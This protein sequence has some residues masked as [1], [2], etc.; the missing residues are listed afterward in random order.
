MF[1]VHICYQWTSRN[2]GRHINRHLALHFF[3]LC[4]FF[5]SIR[6]INLQ[7]APRRLWETRVPKWLL[8]SWGSWDIHPM[9]VFVHEK[10]TC[11]LYSVQF[12]M[13][14]KYSHAR[15]SDSHVMFSPSRN[16]SDRSTTNITI[17][18]F[19]NPFHAMSCKE[20]SHHGALYYS[21][22]PSNSCSK[23]W[24]SPAVW[25]P[26]CSVSKL[27]LKLTNVCAFD[28]K[29]KWILS[30]CI[31]SDQLKGLEIANGLIV[32]IDIHGR[33]P[34]ESVCGGLTWLV[35]LPLQGWYSPEYGLQWN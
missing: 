15:I 22:H 6:L 24:I 12:V 10:E 18:L 13:W 32:M 7:T 14:W 8:S 23:R 11:C 4:R 34:N 29:R 16:T 9:L 3:H 33:C 28:E 20:T 27:V 19:C 21:C 5:L 17:N 2:C 1:D 31:N 35:G 25:C 30:C 26:V